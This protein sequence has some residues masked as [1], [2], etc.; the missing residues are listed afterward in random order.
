LSGQTDTKPEDILK[1]TNTLEIP[2]QGIVSANTEQLY[3]AMH[4]NY[5]DNTPITKINTVS[6]EIDL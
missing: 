6:Y 4:V 5:I 3:S 1:V 2:A